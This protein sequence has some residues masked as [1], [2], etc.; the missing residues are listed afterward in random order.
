MKWPNRKILITLGALLG[1]GL[2]ALGIYV[3]YLDRV[4]R[5]EF[6]GRRWDVPA[7]VYAI[8][9]EL[10][11]GAHLSADDL[12]QELRQLNYR[13]AAIANQAGTYHRRDSTIEVYARAE[14][15]RNPKNHRLKSGGCAD[16]SHGSAAHWQ[17]LPHSR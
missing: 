9:T 5:S 11:V 8:P 3:L 6:E 12:E 13:Q 16:F 7:R 2:A 4:V 15:G 17:H 10:Y 14:Q 1:T